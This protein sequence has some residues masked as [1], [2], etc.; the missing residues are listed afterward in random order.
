MNDIRKNLKNTIDLAWVYENERQEWLIKNWYLQDF[1]IY[2]K[3]IM[4]FKKTTKILVCMGLLFAFLLVLYPFSKTNASNDEKMT[5]RDKIRLERLEICK[6]YAKKHEISTNPY[7]LTEKII[8]CAIRM[9]GVYI[10]ESWYWKSDLCIFKNNCLWIKNSVNSYYWHNWF[11][12]K[13]EERKVFADKYFE[14]HHKKDPHTFIFWYKQKDWS[15]KWGW[16][17]WNRNAYV[18]HLIKIE[19]DINLRIEY[20]YLFFSTNRR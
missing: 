10:F 20:E 2:E 1:T 17:T 8:D 19:N 16:A 6:N 9:H 18:N 7:K 13:T 3:F 11:I 5:I 15:Y 12:S 14:F 4:K